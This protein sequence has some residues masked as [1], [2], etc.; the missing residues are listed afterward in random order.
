MDEAR[1]LLELQ[2]RDLRIMRLNKQL[3][4]MPEKRA[5]LVARAK[6]AE[7]TTLLARTEAAGRAVDVRIKKLDDEQTALA[8]KMEHEQSKLLSG[9]IKNPKELTAISLELDSLKRRREKLEND[10]LAEMATRDT[11]SEQA[12]KVSAVVKAGTAKEAELVATFKARGGGIVSEIE[13]LTGERDGLVAG[14]SPA[15]RERYESI[16][17]AKHG[18]AV[19]LL[20]GDTCGVCRVSMPAE[21][22]ERLTGGP[23][24]GTCPMCQR[25]LVVRKP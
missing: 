23:D 21:R 20:E 11:A 1:T 5:I 10:E 3:D 14:L 8:Q 17:A 9:A 6:I 18:I 16:R 25:L 19:G 2:D 12:T 22:L 15:T 13:S 24:V 4:E 7:I